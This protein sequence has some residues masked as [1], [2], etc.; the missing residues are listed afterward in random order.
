[1]AF[2][3]TN[4]PKEI[5]QEKKY[6]KSLSQQ[7]IVYA[8]DEDPEATCII[9]SF[10]GGD[11][12]AVFGVKSYDLIRTVFLSQLKLMQV[13]EQELKSKS[14]YVEDKHFD[15]VSNAWN[16]LSSMGYN[17]TVKTEKNRKSNNK[18]TFIH[19]DTSSA[20][21]FKTAVRVGVM[22][23]GKDPKIT[24]FNY[25]NDEVTSGVYLFLSET[26]KLLKYMNTRFNF[27]A[28]FLRD[29]SILSDNFF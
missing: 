3:T 18:L 7:K 4:V 13:Q 9:R 27:I 11:K 16:E 25:Y 1:M 15:D 6:S 26:V 14:R 12:F 24:L 20:L 28:G 5:L 8:R 22:V 10:Y 17:L 21:D 19:I 2:K 29:R 23:N